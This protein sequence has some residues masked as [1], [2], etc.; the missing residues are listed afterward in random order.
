MHAQALGVALD[1]ATFTQADIRDI[2]A[3]ILSELVS[4]SPAA[5]ADAQRRA[6]RRAKEAASAVAAASAAAAAAAAAAAPALAVAAAAIAAAAGRVELDDL[7][8]TAAG[9]AAHWLLQQPSI[10]DEL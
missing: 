7:P 1:E 3:R 9:D 4:A 5:A 6:K 8:R 2:R 10:A